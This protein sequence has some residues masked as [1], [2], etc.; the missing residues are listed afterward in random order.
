MIDLLKKAH[1]F[2]KIAHQ[3][4]T[5]KF[6]NEPYISHAEKTAH[7]LWEATKGQ[8]T[9]DEYAAAILHDVVEDTS[10]SLDEIG[11]NFGGNVM[12]LVSELTTDKNKQISEGK[13]HYLARKINAMSESA[14]T[15]KLCDRLHNVM[16]LEDKKVPDKFTIKYIIETHYILSHISRE[17]TKTQENL[18]KKIENVLVFL[19]LNR[20]LTINNG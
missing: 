14:L 16:S 7:I 19:K 1:D 10:I 2:A 18:T 5:R 4:Q 17:L 6:T 15:I 20:N 8:A 12:G 3:G 13:K 11:R 9:H